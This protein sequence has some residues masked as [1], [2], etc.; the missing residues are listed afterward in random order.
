[1]NHEQV[2]ADLAAGWITRDEATWLL[3]PEDSRPDCMTCQDRKVLTGG[4]RWEHCP[5]CIANG[6]ISVITEQRN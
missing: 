1:M 3:M 4:G 6:R 2:T 5:S